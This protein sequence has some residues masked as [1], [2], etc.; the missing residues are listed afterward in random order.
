MFKRVLDYI[1]SVL[2]RPL[3]KLIVNAQSLRQRW[4]TLGQSPQVH[5]EADYDGRRIM[6]LALYQKGQLRPDVERLFKAARKEGLYI[7]AVN[8][9]R[10]ADP[11]SVEGLIDCYIER[12]NFGRDFGSY[13]TGFL[14]VF[15]R[16]WHQ[17]CPRLLMV[18]DSVYFSEERMGT[19]LSEM[20]NSEIE[21]LGATENYEIEFHLGSF[22]IAMGQPVLQKKAFQNYWHSYRL[23]DVR[24]KVIKRG[25]MQLSKT[26]KRCV[27]APS[28]FRSLYSSAHYMRRLN[29]DPELMNI[30]I[31]N[32]RTSNLLH[33]ERVNATGIVT[34]L[35]KNFFLSPY[36][37]DLATVGQDIRVEASIK[38]LN[39]LYAV[40][41]AEGIKTILRHLLND[42]AVLHE[43][44]LDDTIKSNLVQVFM[45]GSQIHQ[46]AAILL[47]LGLPIIKL[48]GLYRGMFNTY[49]I[50]RLSK[51]IAPQ[52]AL[53]LQNLLME[54]P[55]GGATLIGWKRAAFIVGLI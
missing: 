9:L 1:N 28:Q 13:K 16:G 32:A 37:E 27:S 12:P 45:S 23:S 26:L 5:C 15:N 11:S 51:L 3:A 42:E 47:H 36:D 14:H 6:L 8:T 34:F 17:K 48:D 2:L 35:K 20:M 10:L 21:A 55:F 19:F 38:E 49:D 53:E 46:N 30:S 29:E 43:S 39:A 54:R 52:E 44:L 7:V 25:E 18:N 22:C 40:Q 31:R 50:Q 33:W 24:P 41:D 4:K